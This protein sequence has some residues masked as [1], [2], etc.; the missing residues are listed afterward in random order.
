[1][2]QH[3]ERNRGEAFSAANARLDTVPNIDEATR[4]RHRK[5]LRSFYNGEA[6][7][8]AQSGSQN[9]QAPA[10]EEAGDTSDVD[11]FLEKKGYGD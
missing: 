11:K 5:A 1:M 9:A 7:P 6:A 3:E 10:P 8:P 4:E 2:L